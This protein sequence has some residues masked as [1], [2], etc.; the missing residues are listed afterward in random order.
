MYGFIDGA[1]SGVKIFSLTLKTCE[2]Q[3]AWLVQMHRPNEHICKT[4]PFYVFCRANKMAAI[5]REP[6]LNSS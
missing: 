4:I 1:R 5:R 3:Q 6:A 2:V